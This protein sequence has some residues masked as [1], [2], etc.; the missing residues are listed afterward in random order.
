MDAQF[1]E[2][3]KANYLIIIIV[4]MVIFRCLEVYVKNSKSKKDDI[5][6]DGIIAPIYNPLKKFVKSFINNKLPGVLKNESKK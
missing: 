2:F 1:I 4:A 6:F 5:L 3:I